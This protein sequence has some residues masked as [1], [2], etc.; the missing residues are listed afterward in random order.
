[1]YRSDSDSL[2]AEFDGGCLNLTMSRPPGNYLDYA[3]L[4]AIVDL[5]DRAATDPNVRVVV[6]RGAGG[7]FSDG[8]DPNEMG[9][10][11]ERFGSRA[12]GGS[13]GPAPLPQ[14]AALVALRSVMK[15]TIALLEGRALGLAMDLA[16]VC[17]LR[18][19]ASDAVV[20]DTRIHEGR[21]ASTGISYV[22]PRLIGQSQATRVLL[23]GEQLAMDECERIG[24]VHEVID[25]GNFEHQ[26]S[27]RVA[28]VAA[29]PTR[30]WEVHK[31]QVLPQLDLGF[32]AAMTH[33]LGVRQTHVIEDR[34]EG[35]LARREKRKPVFK[36][37]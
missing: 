29:L 6:L 8:D 33:C 16:C 9:A 17:D 5:C 12:P 25:S 18:L 37:R 28:N 32:D 14:Q 36:G 27:A 21:A 20:G 19:G 1:M 15:P 11:P 30:A 26:A 35:A 34:A 7:T 31:K 22:L 13:H 10:W 23:L 3:M 4:G 2:Q 24:L